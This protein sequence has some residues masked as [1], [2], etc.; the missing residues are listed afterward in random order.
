[1]ALGDV[2][3]FNAFNGFVYGGDVDLEGGSLKLALLK[4]G[5]ADFAAAESN[6][7]LG[8]GNLLECTAGGNYVAGGL[9]VTLAIV[10]GAPSSPIYQI[11][12]NT[13]THTDGKFTWLKAAGSP[14]D[15]F[16]L[17]LYDDAAAGKEALY[18][19]DATSDNGV[20][21]ASMVAD[22]FVGHLSTGPGQ[23]GDIL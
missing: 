16:A 13:T 6:P 17:L 7:R 3:R 20:T 14:E 2:I 21:P 8:Q 18:A 4:K 9:S 11:K 23:I 22:D 15:I 19:W 5:F 10:D 12:V 1:M